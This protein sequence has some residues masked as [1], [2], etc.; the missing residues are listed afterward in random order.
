MKKLLFLVVVSLY[1]SVCQAQERDSDP[2]YGSP[3]H[4][5][6][7]T[8]EFKI[9]N[10]KLIWQK[11]Y[12]C[13]DSISQIAKKLKNDG[14]LKEIEITENTIT[15][16]L[17]DIDADYKGAGFSRG[18]TPMYLIS[19]RL[20]C[21]VLIDFKKDKYR[22]TIKNI[23]LTNVLESPISKVGESEPIET[24]ALK[25]KNTTFKDVFL[26]DAATILN[27]TFNK[28]FEN[29]KDVNKDDNW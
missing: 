1:I 16:S 3:K 25:K 13:K 21:F 7:N 6:V 12:E 8:Q 28:I 29:N 23:Q 10:G 22:V 18:L 26:K 15:G 27:Y 11:I 2:I 4:K 5:T 14:I 19:D 20:T 17:K 24:Y 9:S